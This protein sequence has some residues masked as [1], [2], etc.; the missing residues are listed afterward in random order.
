MFPS[1]AGHRW[2]DD[3]VRPWGCSSSLRLSGLGQQLSPEL[4]EL[5]R[6]RLRGRGAAPAVGEKRRVL[7]VP[8]GTRALLIPLASVAP[9]GRRGVPALGSGCSHGN[10]RDPAPARPG[11]TLGP[12]L[13]RRLF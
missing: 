10:R 11:G 8:A 12:H 7:T 1:L 3:N 4:G 2:R 5:P 6:T 9:E 13:P